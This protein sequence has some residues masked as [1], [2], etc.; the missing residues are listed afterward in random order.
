MNN[1]QEIN[2]IKPELSIDGSIVLLNRLMNNQGN[3]SFSVEKTLESHPN[4][5]L[6]TAIISDSD[7]NELFINSFPSKITA[8]EYSRAPSR[9]KACAQEPRI[10]GQLNAAYS[11]FGV[12]LIK[13]NNSLFAVDLNKTDKNRNAKKSER[14]KLA[15]SLS[16]LSFSLAQN[17]TELL[18]EYNLQLS[19]SQYCNTVSELI[20]CIGAMLGSELN[21]GFHSLAFLTLN[22]LDTKFTNDFVGCIRE[23]NYVYSM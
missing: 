17:P 1:N 2:I 23:Y 11:R 13:S 8:R 15:Y 18:K 4:K 16:L 14:G 19:G 9:V 22:G 12:N 21:Y 5:E 3:S 7:L 20:D 6:L 10:L